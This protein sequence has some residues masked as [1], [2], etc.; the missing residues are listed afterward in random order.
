MTGRGRYLPARQSPQP[1]DPRPV[2][3]DLFAGA[4]GLSLG[5]RQAGFRVALA[6]ELDPDAAQTYHVNH[7]ETPVYQADVARL[8][9]NHIWERA[10][11]LREPCALIAGPPCQGYSMAGLGYRDDPRNFLLWEAVRLAAELHPWWLVLENVS[12]IARVSRVNLLRSLVEAMEGAG[13]SVSVNLLEAHH[14][15]VP[16]RRQRVFIIGQR[17]RPPWPIP[18]P[19]PSHCGAQR[20]A[21]ECGLPPTPTVLEA[22]HDLPALGP[23]E[24]A[25]DLLP[26]AST[27]RHSARVVAKIAQIP[28]GLGPLSY[29]RLRPDLACTIVAGHRALPLHPILNRSISVREAARLQGFPDDYVFVGPRSNQPLQVANAVPPPMSRAVA[30]ALA[31]TLSM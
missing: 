14:F 31:S 1:G 28:P 25:E 13:Y 20:Q 26:N 22:L 21:C 18:T 11:D 7:Q 16:Q 12:G 27:M 19:S 4:G 30:E 2:A 29:R 17:G 15:G 24:E 3:V 23:G 9:A 8:T 5:F 6:V 10:A